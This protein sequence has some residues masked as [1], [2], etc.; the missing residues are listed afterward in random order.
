M[1]FILRQTWVL[2][3]LPF[4]T[5]TKFCSLFSTCFPGHLSADKQRHAWPGPLHN[6]IVR[7]SLRPGGNKNGLSA[8][9]RSSFHFRQNVLGKQK[10]TRVIPSTDLYLPPFSRQM[11]STWCWSVPA[12]PVSEEATETI[13]RAVKTVSTCRSTFNFFDYLVIFS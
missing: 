7:T 2:A 11:K 8:V 9:F 3:Y 10:L 1:V 13:W 6:H 5:S 12:I 4:A